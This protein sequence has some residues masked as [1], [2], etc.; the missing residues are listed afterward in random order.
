MNRLLK[1][2]STFAVWLCF[3]AGCA[4]DPAVKPWWTLR[5]A[6]FRQLQPGRATKA[7]VRTALGKADLETTFPRQGEEVWDYRYLDGVMHMLA[8]VYFDAQGG[9]KYYTS[10]PDPAY[11]N[12]RH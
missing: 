3:L 8:W 11:H 4:G 9:Y 1:R 10:Q 5:E 6:V 12:R 2:V 7:D